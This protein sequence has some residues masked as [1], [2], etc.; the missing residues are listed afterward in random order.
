MHKNRNRKV[1]PVIV[2]EDVAYVEL[3]RNQYTTIDAEYADIVSQHNWHAHWDHNI[4]GY[5][6]ET[7]NIRPNT[8]TIKLHRYIWELANGPILPGLEIDH[9]DNNPLLNTIDNLRVVTK[10]ENQSNQRRKKNG[11]CSSKYTGVHWYKRD[12]KWRAQI[13]VNRRLYTIGLFDTEIAA[14]I[15]YQSV[16][17]ELKE[18]GL[19]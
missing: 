3:T 11:D 19:A 5:Y 14:H 4:K 2:D 17:A 15:A 18:A 1:R 12:N 16:L 7:N 6:A 9:I 8:R 10:R 13:K